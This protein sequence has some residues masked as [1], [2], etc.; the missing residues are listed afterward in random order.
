MDG[1]ARAL[2]SRRCW[3]PAGGT[4]EI[5]VVS[6]PGCAAIWP[7]AAGIATRPVLG[8]AAPTD[9]QMRYRRA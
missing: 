4:L 3:S 1:V 6:R 9:V 5:G 7:W 2:C 8:R